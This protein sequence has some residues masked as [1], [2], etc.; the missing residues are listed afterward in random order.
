MKIYNLNR[1]TYLYL[2]LPLGLFLVSWL[3]WGWAII[4]TSSFVYASYKAINDIN[5]DDICI[6]RKSIYILAI[7]AIIWCFLSGIGY[8][9]Y[10]SFDYHFRNAVFR[11]LINYEWP[12][13]YDKA[14]TPLVYYMGFWLVPA[15]IT[16]LLFFIT[17][18]KEVLF[19]IGNIFL[20][21]YSV[22]GVIL[23][24]MQML[25]ATKTWNN[26]KIW[27]VILLFIFFSGLDIIGYK[28]FA[29]YEQPF[30]Y[31]LEWWTSIIQYSSITTGMFWVFNQ[32]IPIA[33][34]T[35]LIYNERNIKNFGLLIAVS[36][37]LSPYPTAGVGI[38]MLVYA[39]YIFI[40]SSDKYNFII[41]NIFSVQNIIGV[42]WLLPVIVSY[43]I[44]NSEGMIGFM[45]VFDYVTYKKL[46]IFLL[47]EFLI[48][49]IIVCKIFY[50][51]IFFLITILSLSV[52]PFLRLDQQNNF[53]MRASI[54]AIVML[55]VYVIRFWYENKNKYF[56]AV[57]GIV[58]IIGAV[59]PITEFYRGFYY[60]KNAK[61]I[62]LV[63]DEIYT[64]N[65][66]Y[67]SM[68]VFGF[69]VNHQYTAQNYT[70]DLF[71]QIFA[72]KNISSKK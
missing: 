33:L 10:Q 8:F 6:N 23:V 40:L 39:I 47:L 66:H 72:S 68:P 28:Y 43:Y 67:I 48:Y 14:N 38:F 35:L 12:V 20:Y 57:L 37:F 5:K 46:I 9:Y 45:F 36:L 69:D 42:F 54:P 62:N 32:F 25:V 4:F 26:K 53:C 51:D 58:F 64:L 31:H 15:L 3:D 70:H 30:E 21:V 24:F 18:N 52:I 29:T 50:K 63:T 13:F 1:L 65:Q 44:T 59:T 17:D 60:I 34:L 2:A 71:W 49:A 27:L 7:I 41:N 16:K 11:D 55:S 19:F 56:S 22:L 61:K